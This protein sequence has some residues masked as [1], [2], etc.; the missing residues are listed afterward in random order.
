MCHELIERLSPAVAE[1]HAVVRTAAIL[2]LVH[3]KRGVFRS[4][5]VGLH[6]DH[7][8][9]D[10]DI[11]G[12]IA[13]PVAGLKRHGPYQFAVRNDL[14]QAAYIVYYLTFRRAHHRAENTAGAKI[15]FAIDRL[16]G[17]WRKPFLDMLGYGP[18]RPDK[19]RRHVD[20]TLQ[21]QVEARIAVQRGGYFISSFSSSR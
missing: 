11:K 5:P 8:R 4:L 7:C 2:V 10:R 17:G 18:C 9:K 21:K 20:H 19:L 15:D 16:P 12:G 6:Q 13:R 14:E 1:P 3:G